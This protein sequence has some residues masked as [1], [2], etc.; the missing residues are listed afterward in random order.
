[1]SNNTQYPITITDP[2]I[3]IDFAFIQDNNIFVVSGSYNETLEMFS[4]NKEIFYT[5]PVDK[6][7]KF[8]GV[9]SSSISENKTTIFDKHGT[10]SGYAWV[11]ID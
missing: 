7:G 8:F 9:F 11:T 1:M 3:N 2:T 4:S 10:E 6:V 5:A